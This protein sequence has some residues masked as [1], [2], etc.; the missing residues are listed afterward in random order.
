MLAVLLG[1]KVKAKV[2]MTDISACGRIVFHYGAPN[3]KILFKYI[4]PIFCVISNYLC[5]LLRLRT[6]R[7]IN[8]KVTNFAIYKLQ[9]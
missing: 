5:D 6:L 8:R 1:L 3:V 2:E 7:F 4:S 9:G